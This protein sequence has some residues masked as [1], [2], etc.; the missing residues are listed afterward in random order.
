[1]KGLLSLL[2]ILTGSICYSQKH[3]LGVHGM[4]GLS[5][6]NDARSSGLLFN[7]YVS[8]GFGIHHEYSI[9]D[10]FSSSLAVNLARIGYKYERLQFLTFGSPV[11]NA[12]YISGEEWHLAGFTVGGIYHFDKIFIGAHGSY[13]RIVKSGAPVHFSSGRKADASFDSSF[14][15]AKYLLSTTLELGYTYRNT[16][17]TT[18]HISL[19]AFHN[20][21]DLNLQNDEFPN[22]TAKRVLW[23]GIK[24]AYSLKL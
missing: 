23:I 9:S 18:G 4:A 8:Y 24:T 11:P 20:F 19:F 5:S 21:S 7:P 2:L 10:R 17:K 13:H 12:R 16:E 14:L 1:M 3:Q 6:S 15:H 22:S